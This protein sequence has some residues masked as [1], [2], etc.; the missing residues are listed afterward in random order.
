MKKMIIL[1]LV[2]VA[3]VLGPGTASA[4]YS[5]TPNTLNFVTNYNDLYTATQPGGV[6]YGLLGSS[7]A[8]YA[9][10]LNGLLPAV[11]DINGPSQFTPTVVIVGNGMLDCS[12][13]LAIIPAICTKAAGSKCQAVAA[14]AGKTVWDRDAIYNSWATNVN[15][16][17]SQGGSYAGIAAGLPVGIELFE[18]LT[19]FIML[20]DSDTDLVV[21]ALAGLLPGGS[22][23]LS[24]YARFA[25]LSK[26][27]DADGDGATNFEEYTAFSGTGAGQTPNPA[28]YLSAVLD[29]TIVPTVT[30]PPAAQDSDGD[31]LSDVIENT[32]THTNPFNA[33]TDGDGVSDGM[34]VLVYGTD[35]LDPN[36]KPSPLPVTDFTGMALLVSLVALAGVGAGLR[37]AYSVK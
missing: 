7:I 12:Y 27:G 17:I 31:G 10:L 30:P 26:T 4:T 3:V 23:D 37:R 24:T 5:G 22:I 32:I 15:L 25:Y 11:A 18:I 35:P 8:Q 16:L 36:S 13:E 1:T 29:P 28:A 2:A 9:S 20:H 21:G 33:D 19:A 14:N 6:L 34:E